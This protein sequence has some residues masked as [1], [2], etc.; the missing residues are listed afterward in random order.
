MIEENGH[1]RF[2]IINTYLEG[3]KPMGMMNMWKGRELTMLQRQIVLQFSYNHNSLI[4]ISIEEHALTS[5]K[6]MIQNC[7]KS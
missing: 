5:L 3:V 4:A 1:I 6:Q 7:K 2:I